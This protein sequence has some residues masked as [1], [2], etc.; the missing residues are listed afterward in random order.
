MTNTKLHTILGAGL[1]ALT[2]PLCLAAQDGTSEKNSDN[3]RLLF[4]S[5][6]AKTLVST[7]RT[8]AFSG[9][10]DTLRVIAFRVGF[11][12]GTRDTSTITTGTGQFGVFDEA[13]E[14]KG[15]GSDTIY[16]Y[17]NL[18]HDKTYFENQLEFVKDYFGTVSR[19]K[20]T[21]QYEVYPAEKDGAYYVPHTIAHY[22]PGSK[23]DRESWDEF[24]ERKTIGLMNF[25][26]DA[27]EQVSAEASL[28]ATLSRDSATGIVRDDTGRKVVF[29]FFHA[30]A[31]YLT[32][33]G[34]QGALGQDT[35]SDMID[36]FVT[37]DWFRFYKDSLG[38]SDNGI[39]VRS[40]TDSVLVDEIMLVSETSNQDELNWG[41]H[42]IIVNQIA[43]QIGI[44][45][46][47]STATG[48]S[49][50][51]AFCIMDF[52]GYSAGYGFVPPWPSA[53]VR[54][55]MGWDTPVIADPRNPGSF[56]LRAVS[57]ASSD[58]DTT[59]L[60]VPINDHEYFLIENRQRDLTGKGEVFQYD[61]TEDTDVP[62]IATY[63]YNVELDSVVVRTSSESNAIME[64][65]NYDVSLPASGIL[66]WHVDE[67]VIQERIELNMVN[68]D[69][70]YRGIS[71]VEADGI[72]DLGVQFI[73][74]FSQAAYDYGGA[75][76]IFPHKKITDDRKQSFVVDSLGPFTRPSTR[77]NDGGHSYITLGITPVSDNPATELAFVRN[78]FVENFVDSV[79]EISVKWT[80]PDAPANEAQ[81]QVQ[82]IL[83]DGW[84]RQVLPDS[85]FF[86]PVV[87]NVYKVDATRELVL[88]AENGAMHILSLDTA[89]TEGLG[90]SLDSVAVSG[91]AFNDSLSSTTPV[92]AGLGWNKV[93]YST[94]PA[95]VR[96]FPSVIG[97]RVYLPAGSSVF[98]LD[99]V[100]APNPSTLPDTSLTA[101]WREMPLPA[102]P[103]S[104]VA[105][106]IG[107][108]WAIGCRG[109]LVFFSD[110]TEIDTGS[111][112]LG[113]ASAVSAI[114]AL[115]GEP[116][117]AVAITDNGRL[118][119][120]QKQTGIL[121]SVDIK[122]GIGPY[123]L[124]T[125]DIDNDQANEILI[126]D[127]RQGV[128]CFDRDLSPAPEWENKPVEWA[129]VYTYTETEADKA[130]SR[131]PVNTSAP[132]LAD[133]N[134]DGALEI[135]VGGTNGI[136]ALNGNGVLVDQWPAYLDN[137]FWFY[138]KSINVSPV[139][140]K[141]T[142]GASLVLF[143]APTGERE[144]YTFFEIDS[145][146]K[147][148]TKVF[149]TRDDGTVDSIGQLSSSLVDTLLTLG[150]SLVPDY[151][152]PGGLL[153]A[154]DSRAQRPDFLNESLQPFI[155]SERQS[156]WPFTI[157]SA[158]ASAPVLCDPDNDNTIDIFMVSDRGWVYRWEL[159][160]AMS[161]DSAFWRQT[162]Y[163]G[164]RGFAYLGKL[165]DLSGT[166]DKPLS[167]YSYPN[168]TNGASSVQF[169]FQ[170]GGPAKDVRLDVFTYTGYHVYSWQPAKDAYLKNWNAVHEL[171]EEIP[172]RKYG[173]GV[174]R[175]RMEATVNGKKEVQFWK[176]A[177]VK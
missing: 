137:R 151:I 111:V 119:I 102:V 168:P 63:P 177:V 10:T 176:M 21:L 150:D 49:G 129:S 99:S 134:N 160:N 89:L 3:Y 97:D 128:W 69:S 56:R 118:Y 33:G 109:G 35:P 88:F 52:A 66:V 8:A 100:S 170:F 36:A 106:L 152:I 84:P 5:K 110:T 59:L 91:V 64:V 123:S 93:Y 50:I 31:S 87:C 156:F 12:G 116:N 38:L 72:T 165:G 25:V 61:T 146:N 94:V 145:T 76:D 68:A 164:S 114:A 83:S 126:S 127:S 17:D 65:T 113:S 34:E 57:N 37:A 28:F 90:S 96:S 174:Y 73:D 143:G 78:H 82:P 77:S 60:M 163:D 149:F 157:G 74:I 124:V 1:L 62:Y 144:T 22:S 130:R 169:R 42:G 67:R 27:F 108:Q 30:G 47:W 175:C 41:I 155:K 2:I 29:L 71:L 85:A 26:K 18:P 140:L 101:A 138:R 142:D 147:Q 125:G 13:D 161:L 80:A 122:G 4:K 46:L 39:Y 136:Y 53:W 171:P 132:S 135:L 131:K 11:N 117:T 6:S 112:V 162:G 153:D 20:L 79:F 92:T 121:D 167:F 55:F 7:A 158:P 16:T 166:E 51:G 32:D 70:S 103:S 120:L 154:R 14:V 43:R 81:K 95:K 75:D 9:A 104:Y 172:L 98:I 58:S 44:P 133:I 115:K 19:G 105:K 15:Y 139:I 159:R 40:G 48:I 45:D 86:E 148:K 23:K 141:Q 173:P 107:E 24:Y 54:L